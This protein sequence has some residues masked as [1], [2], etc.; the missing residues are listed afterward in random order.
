MSF[1]INPLGKIP[2]AEP[3]APKIYSDSYRHP[4]VSGHYQNE[5]SMLSMVRGT[6]IQVEYYRQVLG[7]GEE[8]HAYQPGSGVYQQF[9]R[10]KDLIIKE[11][12]SSFNF[13]P[14]KQISLKTGSAY[15]IFGLTPIKGDVFISETTDGNAGLYLI[16]DISISEFTANKVYTIDFTQLGILSR[17]MFEELN[18]MVVDELVYSRDQHL[19]GGNP[20]ITQGEFDLKKK[21]FSWYKTIVQH[22]CSTYYW[23]EERTLSW[24]VGDNNYYDPYLTKAFLDS[25]HKD[26]MAGYPRVQLLSLE[27]GGNFRA[28]HGTF[29]IWDVFFRND[30][31]LLRRCKRDAAIVDNKRLYSTRLYNNVRSSAFNGIVVTDPENYQDMSAWVSW[32]DTIPTY[33]VLPNQK[34]AYMFTEEFYDGRPQTEFEHLCVDIFKNNIVDL[35][36]LHKYLET[37]WDLNDWERLYYAPLLL[38]MIMRSRSMGKLI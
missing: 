30:W 13:D 38:L 33:N 36:R 16:T 26:A 14:V 18:G 24:R 29:N 21:V 5:N 9:T 22:V 15:V 7:G 37:Y 4:I 28:Q 25:A 19:N 34:I 20:I 27:Y 12:S 11:I 8:P 23:D 10:I 32:R 6:P 3:E 31:N 17:G 35:D 2:A 1:D